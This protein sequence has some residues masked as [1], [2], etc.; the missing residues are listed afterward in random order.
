M[1]DIKLEELLLMFILNNNS[2]VKF[3]VLIFIEMFGLSKILDSYYMIFGY[4]L[5]RK[6][7]IGKKGGGIFVYVNE[8]VMV[9][10]WRD[11]ELDDF[12]IFWF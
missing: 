11:L 7:W 5:Y 1:I 9:L 2:V 3:D 6:D 8:K 4:I 10:C 12:E